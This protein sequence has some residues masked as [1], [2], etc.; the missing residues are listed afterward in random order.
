METNPKIIDCQPEEVESLINFDIAKEL[1][2]RLGYKFDDER[3]KRISDA[4]PVLIN[5]EHI[6]ASLALCLAID[7]E[8]D[9]LWRPAM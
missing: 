5:D 9:L 6:P 7:D 2:I 4:I 3:I 8:L 1:T